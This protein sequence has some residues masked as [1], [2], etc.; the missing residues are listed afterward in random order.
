MVVLVV[1]RQ[2]QQDT[3]PNAKTEEYLTSGVH[4]D[5]RFFQLV[6]LRDDVELDALAGAGQSHAA[7]EQD[8]QD[9]VGKCR[10]EVDSLKAKDGKTVL[11]AL[12]PESDP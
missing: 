4:P 6:P 7:E 2:R 8:D 10:C 11:L 5:F 1:G 3:Q 9:N 12:L